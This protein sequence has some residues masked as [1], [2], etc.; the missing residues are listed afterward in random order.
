[1]RQPKYAHAGQAGREIGVAVVDRQYVAAVHPEGFVATAHGVGHGFARAGP[2]EADD[3]V[4][5]LFQLARMQW[6]AGVLQIVRRRKHPQPQVADTP[7]HERLVG[8]FAAAHHAV[9]IFIDQVHDPVADAHVDLDIG[10]SRVE[11]REGRHEDHAGQ[12]AGH[13]DSQP[14]PGRR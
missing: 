8:E 3:A 4:M 9:H 10:V 5:G 13:V 14:A 2:E 1:M 6:N 11:L 7:G 12:R